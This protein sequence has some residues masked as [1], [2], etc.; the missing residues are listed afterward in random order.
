MFWKL[1]RLMIGNICFLLSI[2]DFEALQT[3]LKSFENFYS[4]FPDRIYIF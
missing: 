2:A 4:A 1:E 3:M